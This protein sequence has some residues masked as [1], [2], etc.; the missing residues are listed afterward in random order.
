LPATLKALEATYPSRLAV[1]KSRLFITYLA[2]HALADWEDEGAP[3]LTDEELGWARARLQEILQ[4]PAQVQASLLDVMYGVHWMYALVAEP[5]DAASEAL[6]DV[7]EATLAGIREDPATSAVNRI[8]TLYG[9][10]CLL[11]TRQPEQAQPRRLV[12]EVG[13]AVREAERATEDPYAR[14]DLFSAAYGALS[15]AGLYDEAYEFMTREVERSHS[16]DYIML[17]LAGW[18]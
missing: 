8:R 10:L 13:R 1:E 4:D 2:A 14:M 11:A 7:W 6:A 18:A 15:V 9:S 3:A 16:P 12:R 5:V 17:S